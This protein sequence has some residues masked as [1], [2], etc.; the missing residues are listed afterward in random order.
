MKYANAKPFWMMVGDPKDKESFRWCASLGEPIEILGVPC[1]IGPQY[2]GFG[3]AVT[4]AVSG[5]AITPPRDTAES[6]IESATSIIQ[7]NGLDA[8][9]AKRLKYPYIKPTEDPADHLI[10]ESVSN[11]NPIKAVARED[12]S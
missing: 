3:F 6:A 5:V 1:L 8:V 2:C 4:D 12:L 10:V 7:K 9:A 11:E